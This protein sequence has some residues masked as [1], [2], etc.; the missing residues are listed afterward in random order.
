MIKKDLTQIQNQIESKQK[1]LKK[2]K[3]DYLLAKMQK[4]SKI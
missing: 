4:Y 2:L 1:E 3:L